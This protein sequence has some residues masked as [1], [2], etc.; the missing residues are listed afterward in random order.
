MRKALSR[1]VKAGKLRRIRQGLYDLPR[2]HPIIGQTAPDVEGTVRALMHG[3]HAQWQFSGAYAA[4]TLGLTEQVPS[5]IVIL[6]DG[7]PRH[8]PLGKLTLIFRRTA[9]RNLLGAGRSAGMFGLPVIGDHLI[10]KGGTS[11]SKVFKLIR[12]FSEDIDVSIDRA[13]LGFGGANELEAGSSSKEKQRRVF[14]AMLKTWESLAHLPKLKAELR[15][16][17]Q[18]ETEAFLEYYHKL[19]RDL[20]AR[21]DQEYRSYLETGHLLNSPANAKRLEQAAE[22]TRKGKVARWSS[23]AE[24]IKSKRG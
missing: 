23:V 12:R 16:L 10:F 4:N 18:S 1:L 22:D 6:T 3:S 15:R 14:V 11:L 7:V 21:S 17:K 19:L 24:L 13:F 8:V 20:V 9:P 2:E 5:K